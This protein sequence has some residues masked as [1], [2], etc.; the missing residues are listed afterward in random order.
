[1]KHPTRTKVALEARV[2]AYSSAV[3]KKKGMAAL[4]VDTV[5]QGVDR[6]GSGFYTIFAS[7]A[8]LLQ[9]LVENE[10]GLS[11]E[12]F[13]GARRQPLGP[14]GEWMQK[15][16]RPLSQDPVDDWV[17]TVLRPYLSLHHVATSSEGCALPALSTDIARIGAEARAV[18]EDA[19]EII[20]KSCSQ[21]TGCSDATAWAVV[22]QC[23][24]TINV[25]RALASD[26]GREVMLRSS[27]DF[28]KTALK[29]EADEI[30]ISA[31]GV[32]LTG[33]RLR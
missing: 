24:G 6:T 28:I 12:R 17:E 11:V 21:R 25:A 26:K 8:E 4:T 33:N 27:F 31:L 14:F 18:Y 15:I 29:K 23:I 22:A 5:M 13:S 19:M 16:R 10:L 30:G 1:M 32:K 2:L 3:A 7:K 20:V 9:A